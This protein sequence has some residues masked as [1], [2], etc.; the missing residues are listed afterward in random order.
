MCYP[1]VMDSSEST[2]K[3]RLPEA[4]DLGAPFVVTIK[5]IVV[6]AE[7]VLMLR[8][9]NGRW[10]LPGG[11]LELGEGIIEGLCREI[12]EET[13]LRVAVERIVD[14]WV[15]PRQIKPSKFVVTYLCRSLIS[16]AVVQ[17]SDEHVEHGLFSPADLSALPML[18]GT[19]GSLNAVFARRANPNPQPP[20]SL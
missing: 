13:G 14:S 12:V 5:G 7:R 2:L 8:K 10:D 3:L 6:C 15:R 9:P 19:R 16:P 17:I 1:Y 18:D 4:A 11:K 20:E